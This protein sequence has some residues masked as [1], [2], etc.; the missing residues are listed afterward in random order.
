LREQLD[1]TGML[2]YHQGSFLQVLEGPTSAV[3]PLLE[4][5][6]VER[7]RVSRWNTPL[8]INHSFYRIKLSAFNNALRL[9]SG[10]STVSIYGVFTPLFAACKSDIFPA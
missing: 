9:L 3:N 2:L 8:S 6:A 1:V 5:I 4:T 7:L 10:I